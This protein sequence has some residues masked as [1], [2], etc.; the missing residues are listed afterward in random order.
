MGYELCHRRTLSR[1]LAGIGANT[2]VAICVC[3][4]LWHTRGVAALAWRC[5]G[6]GGEANAAILSRN[7]ISYCSL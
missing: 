7:S 3:R 4:T 5:Q 6:P 2:K 1:F